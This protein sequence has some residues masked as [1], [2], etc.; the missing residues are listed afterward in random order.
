MRLGGRR[1][2]KVKDC[3]AAGVGS[4][5]EAPTMGF[6]DRPADRQSHACSVGFRG[7]ERIENLVPLG[8]Q[9]HSGIAHTNLY[10]P[11]AVSLRSERELAAALHPPHRFNAVED[12]VH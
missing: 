5:P 11:G 10:F 4:S 9:P 2:S 12:K 1:Q 7:E 6:D 3:A 8:W